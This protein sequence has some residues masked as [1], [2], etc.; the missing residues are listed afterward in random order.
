[1]TALGWWPDAA[2]LHVGARWE[3]VRAR[4]P[5]ADGSL[6][7]RA[8]Y[9]APALPA[10]PD[11]GG[12]RVELPSSDGDS[13]LQDLLA[14]RRTVRT[15]DA[16][17][18]SLRAR[19]TPALGVG[20]ARTDSPQGGDVGSAYEPPGGASTRSR[21][22]FV[23]NVDGLA[24]GVYHYPAPSTPGGNRPPRRAGGSRA[25]DEAMAGQS[26]SS[27]SR[28]SRCDD[29]ALWS[30]NRSTGAIQRSTARSPRRRHLSQTFIS[31]APSLGS[32]LRIT[33]CSTRAPRRAALGPGS[34]ARGRRRDLRL[35]QTR[36]PMFPVGP[37]EPTFTPLVGRLSTRPAQ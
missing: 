37:L 22:T 21:C 34:A 17:R 5:R 23:R 35:R 14:R 15:F 9:V 7:P 33:A 11:R 29:R 19:D 26:G 31:S 25:A 6:P 13:A 27:P 28:T 1:L 36:A 12:S 16:A 4:V 32:G 20:R 8:P 24:P 30:G 2:A 3:G 10:F 18:S